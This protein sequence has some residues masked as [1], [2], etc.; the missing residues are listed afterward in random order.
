M[1]DVKQGKKGPE[2]NV[3]GGDKVAPKAAPQPQASAPTHCKADGCKK[4][5]SKFGFCAEH[6]EWYMSG[7]LRGD[8]KKPIDFEQKLRQFH[9]K[10][11]LRKAA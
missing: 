3:K 7:V 1:S 10:K 8:G 4:S 5:I 2:A 9:E 11:P 6:Y